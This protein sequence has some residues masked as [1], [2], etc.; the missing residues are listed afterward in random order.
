MILITGGLGYLGS[1]LCAM[2][3]YHKIQYVIYDNNYYELKREGRIALYSDILN[4]VRLLQ[5]AKECDAIVHLAAIVGDPAC[6]IN[7]KEAMRVNVE[8]TK[9]V[10]SVAKE[11]EI[12]VVHMST[13]S[14][15]G[16]EPGKVMSETSRII[17]SD[18]YGMTKLAQENAITNGV[19]EF[20]ILRLGTAFGHSARMRYDLVVNKFFAQA[21]NGEEL[22][23]FGGGQMR[24]FVHVQD[25][26]RA[27][28]YALNKNLRGVYNVVGFN[29]T[30]ASI[31]QALKQGF[32]A[33]VVVNE[34]VVDHRWYEVSN[35]KLRGKK[36][37][38]EYDLIAGL[39]DLS[40]NQGVHS[41][42]WR[43]YMY[44]NDK[45]MRRKWK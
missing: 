26:A 14:V 43:D 45:L 22:S 15:Y 24:P 41:E 16:F 12:P 44:H 31:A 29:A 11:L 21:V 5:A 9:T 3:K 30:I 42:R 27:I 38:F 37:K 18:F 25:I 2:L 40:D 19:D 8:G 6:L 7:A 13:C 23:V 1:V 39:K 33:S 10:A 35:T 4:R 32:S 36:F 17:P 20:C 28:T 34:S